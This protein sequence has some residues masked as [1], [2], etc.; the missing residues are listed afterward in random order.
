MVDWLY[1]NIIGGGEIDQRKTAAI[2]LGT[3]DDKIV[4]RRIKPV[5]FFSFLALSVFLDIF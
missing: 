2:R 5:L 3:R 4:G 1:G